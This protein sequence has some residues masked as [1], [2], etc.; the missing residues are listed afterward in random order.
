MTVSILIP[1][2]NRKDIVARSI[3][4]ALAQ[5][6]ADIEIVVTDNCSSDG[7]FEALQGY[8]ERGVRLFQTQENVGPLYNW[9]NGLEKCRGEYV[10]VLWSD[11]TIAPTFVEE[12]VNVMQ[13]NP[14][15]G[16]VFSSTLIHLKN[17]DISAYHMPEY[18]RMSSEQYALSTILGNDMPVSPGCA[19]VRRRDA[20]FVE[21][22][23]GGER[24]CA[25][26]RQF[27]AGPDVYFMLKA[28]SRY[29]RVAHIPKFLSYFY[30]DDQ[31]FTLQN[32]AE[33]LEGYRR[34]YDYLVKESDDPFF[35]SLSSSLRRAKFKKKLKKFL[36]F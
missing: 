35:R 27:G 22:K 31:S 14:D 15:V 2:Y 12:C 18:E 8:S 26:A 28:A 16:L 32:R 11:D 34:T 5:T 10:K 25:L 17:R 9:I 33:V 19:M 6:Y 4:S 1:V 13:Q 30:G 24:L 21:L 36:S 20:E 3:E 23:S 7:T 29:P